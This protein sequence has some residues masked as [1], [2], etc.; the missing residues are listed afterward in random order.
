[1]SYRK[2][3]I[4]VNL[5]RIYQ[6]ILF[7]DKWNLMTKKLPKFWIDFFF[8]LNPF[9]FENDW[10]FLAFFSFWVW[11]WLFFRILCWYRCCRCS[12]RSAARVTKL[13]SDDDD[14]QN[15]DDE[16]LEFLKKKTTKNKMPVT[17]PIFSHGWVIFPSNNYYDLNN[18]E[19]FIVFI[20]WEI[21][22]MEVQELHCYRVSKTFPELNSDTCSCDNDFAV[23]VQNGAHILVLNFLNWQFYKL[24]HFLTYWYCFRVFLRI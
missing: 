7:P 12:L 4:V 18:F 9:E 13:R 20:V 15:D 2:P 11:F 24:P 21:H 8:L 22:T 16:S 23:I 3:R 5:P 17:V 1:M 10:I 19:F 6:D 14:D